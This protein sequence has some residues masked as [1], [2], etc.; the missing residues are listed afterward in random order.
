MSAA[1]A[2]DCAVPSVGPIEHESCSIPASRPRRSSGI[3]WF[4][5]VERKIPD[6]MSAA[7]ASARNASAS[8]S[9]SGEPEQATATPASAA[10]TAT[11]RPWRV[12]RRAQPLVSVSSIAPA[13]PAAKSRPSTSAPPKRCRDRREQR[14][15]HREQHR[16]DVDEVGPDQVL[17]A[18]RVAPA[19]G[20]PGEARRRRPG[21]GGTARIRAS[22]TS[23]TR[24]VAAS[25]A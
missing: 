6:D 10:L 25:T 12:T 24:N 1:S 3:V 4:H 21:G 5:I 11:A 17:A 15:R 19:L 8:G 22:A 14:D 9:E 18:A 2:P 20:D 7:P 23:E 13:G 16:V